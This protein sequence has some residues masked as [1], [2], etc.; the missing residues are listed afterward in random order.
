MTITPP[1]PMT[2]AEMAAVSAARRSF[3]HRLFDRDTQFVETVL[4]WLLAERADSRL[5]SGAPIT[6]VL[7]NFLPTAT[8]L[9]PDVAVRNGDAVAGAIHLCNESLSR[10]AIALGATS[11]NTT[12]MHQAGLTQH[13]LSEQ[14]S[15]TFNPNTGVA[16]IRLACLQLAAPIEMILTSQL[17]SMWDDQGLAALPGTLNEFHAGM[18]PE[19]GIGRVF[20]EGTAP[21]ALLRMYYRNAIYLFLKF[22]VGVRDANGYRITPKDRMVRVTNKAAAETVAVTA[23]CPG[24]AD[25]SAAAATVVRVLA[26]AGSRLAQ[27]NIPT[28]I[29]CMDCPSSQGVNQECAT[30]PLSLRHRH[31]EAA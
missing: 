15:V 14:T 30:P 24:S 18:T 5:T 21:R 9:G 10:A 12:A 6:L 20:F 22:Q 2:Q 8:A 11:L 13:Q 31:V 3:S 7:H 16:Q 4:D 17:A 29:T 25:A 26:D 23:I 28:H 27:N 1:P 19:D